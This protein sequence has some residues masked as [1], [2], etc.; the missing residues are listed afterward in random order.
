M[1]PLTSITTRGG[2]GGGVHRKL[3]RQAFDLDIYLDVPV[4][5]V[6]SSHDK[7]I[8]SPRGGFQSVMGEGLLLDHQAMVSCSGKWAVH[9]SEDHVR[10]R[11]Y[12]IK[13]V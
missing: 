5:L 4:L 11:N 2:G 7:A 10:L 13:V 8:F 1:M 6:A 9:G 12:L 3:W